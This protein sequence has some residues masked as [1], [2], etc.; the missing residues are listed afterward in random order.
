MKNMLPRFFSCVCVYVPVPL[1]YHHLHNLSFPFIA[2]THTWRSR[3]EALL[4]WHTSLPFNCCPPICSSHAHAYVSVHTCMHVH[5]RVC[6][7][8][9]G[10]VLHIAHEDMS[11]CVDDKHNCEWMIMQTYMSCYILE[12]MQVRWKHNWQ[13]RSSACTTNRVTCLKTCFYNYLGN[14]WNTASPTVLL[15]WSSLHSAE[16]ENAWAEVA[17]VQTMLRVSVAIHWSNPGCML[18]SLHAKCI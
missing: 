17:G 11:C 5:A 14:F 7:S 8:E 18:G 13:S 12:L 10:T 9:G 16:E 4:A 15:V 2:L 3:P 6:W 1:W